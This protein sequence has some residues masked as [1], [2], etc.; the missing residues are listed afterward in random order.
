MTNTLYQLRQE[1]REIRKS[2]LGMVFP[3]LGASATPEDFD[4][5]CR[6]MMTDYDIEPT[7]ENWV[8]IAKQQL[9]MF[10][11]YNEEHVLKMEEILLWKEEK[12]VGEVYK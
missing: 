11:E 9:R 5:D 12:A 10:E 4:R 6:R 7:P 3:L 2:A 8:E 1:Y